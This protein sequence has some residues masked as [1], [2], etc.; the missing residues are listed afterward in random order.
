M[1]DTGLTNDDVDALQQRLL[2]ESAARQRAEQSLLATTIEQTETTS[3]LAAA[4]ADLAAAKQALAAVQNQS[5]SQPVTNTDVSAPPTDTYRRHF[6]GCD[7]EFLDWSWHMACYFSQLDYNEKEQCDIAISCF[8]DYAL[9]WWNHVE[10][11][12]YYRS[13]RPVTT[14]EQLVYVMAKHFAP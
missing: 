14:W 12:R 4:L 5:P 13:W 2:G 6:Y 9:G 1:V 8:I 10:A 11:Y 7:D 3:K